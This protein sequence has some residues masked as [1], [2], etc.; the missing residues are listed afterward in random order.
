[1]T[2]YKVSE[3]APKINLPIKKTKKFLWN[4]AN[5]TIIYPSATSE[6]TKIKALPL[7]IEYIKSPPNKGIIIFG[8]A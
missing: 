4:D 7:P 8:K 3:P 2:I 1:M 5:V 6:D